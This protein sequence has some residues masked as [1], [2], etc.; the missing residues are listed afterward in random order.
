MQRALFHKFVLVITPALR[1]LLFQTV[2]LQAN[3]WRQ[4]LFDT[5]LSCDVSTSTTPRPRTMLDDMG[6]N[7]I[8]LVARRHPEIAGRL[9]CR[10]STNEVALNAPENSFPWLPRLLRVLVRDI[11]G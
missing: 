7:L 8:H 5:L 4:T 6:A 1:L 2:F 9:A 11:F 10:F 3:V